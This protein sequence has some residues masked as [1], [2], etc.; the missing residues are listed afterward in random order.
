MKIIKQC[1]PLFIKSYPVCLYLDSSDYNDNTLYLSSNI[2]YLTM[3]WKDF[4]NYIKLNNYKSGQV[5]SLKC[6]FYYQLFDD[7]KNDDII[8]LLYENNQ[9]SFKKQDECSYVNFVIDLNVIKYMRSF[10]INKLNTIT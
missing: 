6:F 5:L 7:N 1:S 4:H 9:Y 8:I 2:N 3:I 10:K